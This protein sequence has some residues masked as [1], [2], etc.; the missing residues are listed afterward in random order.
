MKLHSRYSSLVQ[1]AERE[2]FHVIVDMARRMEASAI[3][4]GT[5]KQYVAQSSGSKL[6]RTSDVNLSPLSEAV[7]K[8]KKGDRGLR[9]SKKNKFWNRIKSGLGLGSGSSSGTEVAECTRCG[10]PHKGVCRFG[11]TACYRCGQE[12]HIARECPKAAFMT[13]SHQTTPGSM[14][15]PSAPAMFQGS[16]RGGDRGTAPSSAGSRGEGPS[17]PARIF[18]MTQQEANTSNP[19]G[20]GNLTLVCSD[21]SVL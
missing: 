2:S 4:Q 20:S 14:A 18:A 7:T 11:T 6:P 12:G 16:G 8:S 15:Q 1:S 17:A 9:R 3:D 19:M 13:P 10:R 21:V 5:V